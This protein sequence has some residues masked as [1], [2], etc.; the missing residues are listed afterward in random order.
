MHIVYPS[1]IK[2]IKIWRNK[3]QLSI[4][5]RYHYTIEAARAY[6][7]Y[8]CEPDQL[9][10]RVVNCVIPLFLQLSEIP[11]TLF[12]KGKSYLVTQ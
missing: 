7:Q 1:N 6:M 3:Y 8:P 9:L 10:R 11:A 12:Q 2:E 5:Y 4:V